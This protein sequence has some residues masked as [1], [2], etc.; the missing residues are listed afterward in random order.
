MVGCYSIANILTICGTGC[1][2]VD[3]GLSNHEGSALWN[4]TVQ[5]PASQDIIRHFTS[6]TKTYQFRKIFNKAMTCHS[7]LWRKLHTCLS[8]IK[9]LQHDDYLS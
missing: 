1:V 9:I 7:S 4:V 3:A 6:E 2:L 5:Y 8:Q